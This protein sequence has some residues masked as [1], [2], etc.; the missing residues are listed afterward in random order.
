MTVNANEQDAVSPVSTSTAREA[1]LLCRVLSIP[2]L[3]SLDAPVVAV[4]W[5]HLFAD[6]LH[7]PSLFPGVYTM[8][9]CSVWCIYLS[10]R[11]L[12]TAPW[13]DKISQTARHRFYRKHWI[14]LL[15]LTLVPVAWVIWL[16]VG[17]A[18][19]GT[20][21]VPTGIIAGGVVMLF[22][23]VVYFVI[24]LTNHRYMNAICVAFFGAILWA[25]IASV[26]RLPFYFWGAYMVLLCLCCVWCVSAKSAT[27]RILPRELLC[28]VVFAMGTVLPVY[29]HVSDAIL[30]GIPMEMIFDGN[31]LINV[32]TFLFAALCVLNCVAISVWEKAADADGNDPQA[33]AQYSPQIEHWFPMLGVSLIV[34]AIGLLW[35]GALVFSA[36]WKIKIGIA[37]ATASLLVVH[38]LRARLHPLASRVLADA[39]LLWPLILLALP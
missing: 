17:D 24:R 5:A 39:V 14:K 18:L 25:A 2:H 28:G 9:F 30:F 6:A 10:D 32:D 13:R 1:G 4:V 37:L 22:L 7:L 27:S 33:V 15:L 11:L 16:G 31:L 36:T 34:V 26:F 3:L 12:D 19:G 29:W 20:Y 23:V 35:D 38:S 21:G 8:L